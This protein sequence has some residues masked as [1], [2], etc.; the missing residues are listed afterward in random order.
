MSPAQGVH[1]GVV[2]QE[3]DQ[4]LIAGSFATGDGLSEQL[5]GYG[6]LDQGGEEQVSH[7]A[8]A[9][10]GVVAEPAGALD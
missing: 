2:V 6:R 7:Q 9:E 10:Q 3:P 1:A 5:P 8:M 4:D